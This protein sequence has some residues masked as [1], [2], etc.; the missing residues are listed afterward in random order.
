MDKS[1]DVKNPATVKVV[2]LVDSVKYKGEEFF[3][4]KTPH[5]TVSEATA[6]VMVKH[7][8]AKIVTK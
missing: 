2:L 5:L 8:I 3:K 1:K 7:D 4:S 6:N